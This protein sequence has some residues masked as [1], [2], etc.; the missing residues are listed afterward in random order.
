LQVREASPA[1]YDE[2]SVGCSL[3]EMI[4]SQTLVLQAK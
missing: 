4:D 1:E 3:A 2:K